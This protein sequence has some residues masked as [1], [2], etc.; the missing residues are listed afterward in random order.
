MEK[1]GEQPESQDRRLQDNLPPQ[2]LNP[3]M[4]KEEDILGLSFPRKL[5][6]IVED[7]AFTSVHWN[8]KGD[9]VVIKADLFQTEVLQ[10]RGVGRIFETD[11]IQSFICELEL[12]EFS[13]IHPLGSS[14]GKKRM[15]VKKKALPGRL[16]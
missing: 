12:Y 3:K 15:M 7:A 1:Q 8:N 4:A 9:T 10:G 16:D 14:E 6:R 13:K 2:G 5:W 11:S